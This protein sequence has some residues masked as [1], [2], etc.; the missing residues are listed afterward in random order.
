MSPKQ[1]QTQEDQGMTTF[2]VRV[3]DKRNVVKR[4][5]LVLAASAEA[6]EQMLR[7]I[8]DREREEGEQPIIFDGWSLSIEPVEFENGVCEV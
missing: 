7:A 6:A 5:W 4:N 3:L 1:N 2:I 8:D